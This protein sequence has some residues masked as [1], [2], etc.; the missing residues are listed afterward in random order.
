MT[1][2]ITILAIIGALAICIVVGELF[3]RTER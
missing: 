3:R 2:I 1:I